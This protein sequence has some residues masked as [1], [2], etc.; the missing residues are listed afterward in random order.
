[1]KKR[2][3]DFTEQCD[4]GI[5]FVD[6]LDDGEEGTL[7]ESDEGVRLGKDI[8]NDDEDVDWENNEETDEEVDG[9]NDEETDEE[10]INIADLVIYVDDSE[11]EFLTSRLVLKLK[12]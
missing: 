5:S 4:D 8:N 3:Y 9:E 12:N 6:L 2:L 10:R 1:M 7:S 11:S